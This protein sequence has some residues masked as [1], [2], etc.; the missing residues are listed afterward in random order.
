MQQVDA[1]LVAFAQAEYAAAADRYTGATHVAYRFYAVLVSA[2]R[3]DFRIV[4]FPGIQIVIIGG[5]P[6]FLKLLR[7][8]AVEHAERA[9][10]FHAGGGDGADHF[11]HAVKFLAVANLPPGGTHA[12]ARAAVGGS[13]L[14]G[15]IDRS[16]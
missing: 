15:L 11:E 9:T 8:L 2:S 4:I 10:D 1:V 6:S 13:L 5:E 14:G 16:Y 3:D 12:E 7:L